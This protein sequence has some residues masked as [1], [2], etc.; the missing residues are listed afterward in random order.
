VRYKLLHIIG[1]G[2]F[3]GAEEH[4][5]TL[6]TNIDKNLFDPYLIC[7]CRGPLEE[8]AKNYGI[9]VVTIDMNSNSPLSVISKIRSFIYKNNIDLVH[10]H[11]LRANFLG[12]IASYISKRKIITTVHSAVK[13]DYDSKIKAYIA[14]LLNLST[15]PLATKIIAVSNSIK[16]DLIDMG[17]NEKKIEVIYNGIDYKKYENPMNKEKFCKIYN[18]DPNYPIVSV[19]A[20]L[21]PVK[22]HKYFLEAAKKILNTKPKVQFLLVGDGPLR[23]QLMEYTDKLGLKKN[24][25]FIGYYSPVKDVLNAIDILCLPSLMEGM[26]IVILESFYFSKP[27]VATSVGGIPEVIEDNK[28]GLVV[29]PQNPDEIANKILLL[30]DNPDL[31]NIIITNARERL[32]DF[33]LDNMVKKTENLYLKLLKKG[34]I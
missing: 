33:S 16:K 32:K 24:V 26:G 31:F 10:T 17:I 27:V 20:R 11:G 14:L 15:S 29:S 18:L 23:K 28:T 25:K 9:N 21:H 22:G 19:I 6:L 5:I 30:L 3:G 34:E 8:V 4:V 7:L 13:L 12:R 2:E 1:G